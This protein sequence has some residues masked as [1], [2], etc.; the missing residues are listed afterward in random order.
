M[1]RAWLRWIPAAAVPAL[2]GA[3]V[4][5]GSIPAS[6]GNPLPGKT[7]EQVL[8][9]VGGHRTMAFSGTL[10]QSSE[11]GLP[12]LSSTG[13]S[14]PASAGGTASIAELLT[15]EHT[16]RVFVD[17]PAKVRIQ[18]VDRLAERDLIKRDSEVWFYSS[19]DNTAAHLTLPAFARD[20]PLPSD[21]PAALP[22]DA[23]AVPTPEELARKLLAKADAST[24]VTVG[25][26]VE[27]AGRAAYNLLLQPRTQET[28]VGQ[29]AIAVDGET[30]MPLRVSVNARGQAA[31]A[32]QSG[33]TS[34]S[35]TAPDE[36][37]F[38]FVPPPGATVKELPV[39]TGDH[40]WPIT[41]TLPGSPGMVTPD[42]FAQP[43]ATGPEATEQ[44]RP[45]HPMSGTAKPTVTGKG[46]EAVVG[47][48]AAQAGQGAALSEAL[49]EDPFLSQAA[50]VVPGGRLLSTPL[51]NVLVTD[52]G[53]IFVGMVPP[54]RLQ[55]AAAAP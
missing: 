53:R 35:L 26:D 16:A 19:K 18:V 9:M 22:P 44:A 13:P 36:S 41:S 29:V 39:P 25:P 7:P 31:P 28:L 55:A 23:A 20:L 15:G 4:L 24:E 54:E 12:E 48:P 1:N 10:Q 30:G 2:I 34:L 51:V 27:V 43:E 49:L 42:A 37:R 47:F 8:A 52:D 17:G 5:A 38:T 11:L 3:G 6:A 14:G 21:G 33:F 40:P 32:F 45:S 46:W 50:A